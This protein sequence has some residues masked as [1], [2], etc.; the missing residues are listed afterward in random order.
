V[1]SY[2]ITGP[3]RR[4]NGRVMFD[5]EPLDR[6][7]TEVFEDRRL[8]LKGGPISLEIGPGTPNR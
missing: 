2:H 8:T 5:V 6:Q 1:A 4:S 7:T 3:G